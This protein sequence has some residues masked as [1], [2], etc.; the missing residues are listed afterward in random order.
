MQSE[1]Q[2]LRWVQRL[3]NYEKAFESLALA[4]ELS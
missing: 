2:N 3:S 4:I 1:T